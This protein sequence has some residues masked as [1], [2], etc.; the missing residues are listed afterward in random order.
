MEEEL[1]GKIEIIR[2][3]VSSGGIYSCTTNAFVKGFGWMLLD[4]LPQREVGVIVLRRDIAATI[5]SLSA[6]SEVPSKSGDA[7]F[8]LLRDGFAMNV[9]HKADWESEWEWYVREVY[10]RGA[11]M[12]ARYKGVRFVDAQLEQLNTVEGALELFDALG[13]EADGEHLKQVAGIPL[14]TRAIPADDRTSRLG[15]IYA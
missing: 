5:D 4:R 3:C 8:W 2:G 14:N 15:E 9:T 7:G 13:L 6:A 10:W 12:R 1:A 11:A